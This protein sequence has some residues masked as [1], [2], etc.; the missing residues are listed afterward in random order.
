MLQFG[1]TQHPVATEIKINR[2]LQAH[3]V[4]RGPNSSYVRKKNT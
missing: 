4:D 2:I 3:L 1:E